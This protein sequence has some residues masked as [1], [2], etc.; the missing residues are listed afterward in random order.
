MFRVKLKWLDKVDECAVCREDDCKLVELPICKHALCGDC[1]RSILLENGASAAK[2]PL[3][4]RSEFNEHEQMVSSALKR[5]RNVEAL[6]EQ[7]ETKRVK[8]EARPK[9]GG[10]PSRH[11]GRSE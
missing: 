6:A 7:S 8:T 11:G 3:C 10:T 9:D 5:L 4:R 1:T 2:C